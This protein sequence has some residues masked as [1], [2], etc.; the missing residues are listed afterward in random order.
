M[1]KLDR[2]N[3][4]LSPIHT[5]GDKDKLPKITFEIV[6]NFEAEIV[7]TCICNYTDS[8]VSN[9]MPQS[10][11]FVFFGGCCFYLQC[12]IYENMSF[13]MWSCKRTRD[14]CFQS[15]S[16]LVCHVEIKGKCLACT[17]F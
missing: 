1:E 4:K 12:W 11:F 2:K 16:V 13:F 14:F 6:I 15:L 7:P 9:Y 17:S 8:C 5:E 3:V 10:I